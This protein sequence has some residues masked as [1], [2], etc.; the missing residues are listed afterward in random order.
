MTRG[1]INILN[2]IV[3]SGRAVSYGSL[4]QLQFQI[5]GPKAKL[6]SKNVGHDNFYG[7][8][9]PGPYCNL[10]SAGVILAV[11]LLSVRVVIRENLGFLL[12]N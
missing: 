4:L 5:Y 1:P 10:L 3:L 12:I 2:N 11:I 7:P 9:N 6:N 8:R